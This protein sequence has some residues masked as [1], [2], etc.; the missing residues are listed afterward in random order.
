MN[1]NIISSTEVQ[2]DIK[3][4]LKR[5]NSSSEALVVVRDS[6]PEAV[7]VPYSEFRRLTGLEKEV[8]KMQMEK[9]WE[10]MRQRN[11]DIPDEEIDKA[12]AEAKSHAKRNS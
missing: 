5:L 4:V 7:L 8:I 10:E 12:I 3:S 2:R 9:V 1:S 6:K 11:K